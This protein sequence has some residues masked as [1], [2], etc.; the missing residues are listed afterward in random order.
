M[1][2][3]YELCHG[4]CALRY[5]G[6]VL[7]FGKLGFWC[8]IGKNDVKMANFRGL[9][10]KIGHY[11]LVLPSRTPSWPFFFEYFMGIVP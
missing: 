3:F 5:V 6:G 8:L 7:E 1:I 2:N 10:V 9:I 4:N 11:R